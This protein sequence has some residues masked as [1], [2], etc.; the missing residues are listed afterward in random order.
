MPRAR[1]RSPRATSSRRRPSTPTPSA[2]SRPTPRPSCTECRPR[3]AAAPARRTAADSDRLCA[4]VGWLSSAHPPYTHPPPPCSPSTRPP[5]LPPAH[6]TGYA[7]SPSPRD[8]FQT[9]YPDAAKVHGAGLVTVLVGVGEAPARPEAWP[10][11]CPSGTIFESRYQ[12][13]SGQL[14]P[15]RALTVHTMVC[16]SVV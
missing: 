5:S 12:G 8:W 16:P 13:R 4:L 11:A 14:A 7:R 6:P 9:M 15:T 2:S 3:P 1:R 10:G